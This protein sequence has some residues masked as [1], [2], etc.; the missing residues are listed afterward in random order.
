VI[1]VATPVVGVV[2]AEGA[3]GQRLGEARP[4][5][6]RL[7][8]SDV[9]GAQVGARVVRERLRHQEVFAGVAV[10]KGVVRRAVKRARAA[11]RATK[12]RWIQAITRPSPS[13]PP[14][15]HA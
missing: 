8:G 12:A 2:I 1:G 9:F 14:L 6:A 4:P 7:E 3:P 10:Q 5:A 13:P 15:G 11:A